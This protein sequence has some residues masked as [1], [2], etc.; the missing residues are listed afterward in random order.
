M[1]VVKAG[2]L[3]RGLGRR[4]IGAAKQDVDVARVADGV[5]IDAADP[6][7]DG[8]AAGDGIGDAGMVQRL[9]GAAQPLLDLLSRYQ[10][11]LPA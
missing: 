9:R 2:G 1:V 4:Q 5:F 7:G 3:Q 8:I 6:L 10:R 11:S